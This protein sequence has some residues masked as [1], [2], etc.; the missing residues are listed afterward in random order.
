MRTP[1]TGQCCYGVVPQVIICFDLVIIVYKCH[2]RCCLSLLAYI[3]SHTH[4]THTHTHTSSVL[5]HF[6]EVY[7]FF[8]LVYNG[9][10]VSLRKL[11]I[12][13]PLIW[14]EYGKVSSFIV[15]YL[16]FGV[17]SSV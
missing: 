1:P 15:R 13:I 2:K 14:N 12:L 16:I 11:L 8:A 5:S 4:N 9:T 7:T 6:D 3:Y 17:C 10:N